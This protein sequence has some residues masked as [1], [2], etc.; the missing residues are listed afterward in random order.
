[1]NLLYPRFTFRQ[2][3]WML[4]FGLAGAG[5]AG[6]YGIIHDQITYTIGPEYFTKFKFDQFFYLNQNQP[7]R[8]I[9]ME[10]GFLATWWVGFFAGW[11]LGRITVP[12]ETIETAAKHTVQGVM[13][14]IGTAVLFGTVAA[15]LKPAEINEPSMETWK[16]MLSS[17]RVTDT[18]AFLR[19]GNI[20]NGSYLG[21]LIGLITAIIWVRRR[22][23]STS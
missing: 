15:F 7:Q 11:F 14:I 23:K 17:F 13:I 22:I 6:L 21:G 5:I 4:L 18:A 1:M 19:V 2:F 9:V 10:I 16:F 12:H 3:C 8:V 20:H